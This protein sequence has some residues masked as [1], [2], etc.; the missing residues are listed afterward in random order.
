MALARWYQELDGRFPEAIEEA[1]ASRDA[2]RRQLAWLVLDVTGGAPSNYQKL[3]E[4]RTGISQGT[5]SRYL[6]GKR[7]IHL[8]VLERLAATTG[9]D[10]DELQD[11][12]HPLALHL[13]GGR[14][15]EPG[16]DGWVEAWVNLSSMNPRTFAP[17]EKIRRERPWLFPQP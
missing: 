1:L 9:R 6:K 16:D 10:I 8:D 2:R 7:G 4:S 13:L 12:R 14:S 3:F 11:P 17:L 15:L 5:L